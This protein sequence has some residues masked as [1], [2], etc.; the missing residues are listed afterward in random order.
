MSPGELHTLV[1]GRTLHFGPTREASCNSWDIGCPP[2]EAMLYLD[3]SGGGWAGTRL[4]PGSPPLP[5]QISTVIAWYTASPSLLCVSTSPRVGEVP[6]FVPPR[7][8]CVQV[9]RGRPPGGYSVVLAWGPLGEVRPLFIE[10]TNTF[11]PGVI[12]EYRLQMRVLYGGQMPSW[13]PP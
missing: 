3:R 7:F 1:A 4:A 8:R 13:K 11:P 10:A 9:L 2:V 12:D 6:Y 5:G